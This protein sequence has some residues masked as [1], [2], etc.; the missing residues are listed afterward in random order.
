M[1]WKRRKP[2]S[3]DKLAVKIYG[4]DLKIL[5]EKGSEVV[6]AMRPIRGVDDL[7]MLRVTGQPN[8]NLAVDRDAAA[9]FQN[10]VADV[11]DAIQTAVGGNAARRRA[12]RPGRAISS[13]LPGHSGRDRENS[14]A[15][16]LWRTRLAR[17]TGATLPSCTAYAA[18]T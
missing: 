3:K 11:Q 8:L 4:D 18:G 16:A 12:L 1:R 2:A 6:R 14:S 13:T 17:R 15:F 9:R 10:N 5:E 7:G